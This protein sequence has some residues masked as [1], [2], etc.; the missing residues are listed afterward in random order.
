MNEADGGSARKPQRETRKRIPV[1][2]K[3]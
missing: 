2:E 1:R 3:R